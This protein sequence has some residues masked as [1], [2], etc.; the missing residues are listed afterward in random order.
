MILK[1]LK[2]C[3]HKENEREWCVEGKPVNDEYGQWLTFNQINLIVGRNASGKTKTVVVI[4]RIADLLAGDIKL[5]DLIYDTASYE[6]LFQDGTDEINY[7]LDFENGKITQ[8]TLSINGTEKLNRAKETLFYEEIG[9]HLSFKTDDDS[10]ALARRDSKQQPF[11]ES[12]YSWGKNLTHYRFAEQLGQDAFLKDINRV[13]EDTKIN[14]KDGDAV[15]KA[16]VK[17]K[18]L[19]DA[20]FTDA[21]IRDMRK[22][23]YPIRQ[24]D[25]APLKHW[26]IGFALNVQEE[27]LNDVT[28]QAEMSQGMFRALSLLIQI[29]YS[30]FAKTASCILIDDIGEGLDYERSKGLIDLIIEKVKDSSI[31]VI[32]TSNDRF[33]MNKIPLEYWSVIHRIKNKSVFYNYT[34][35][36]Q[37]FDD[38]VFTG[39]NNFD[40]FATDFFIHGF[41]EYVKDVK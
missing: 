4:R 12:L 19:F 41:E 8:E 34:N 1:A 18:H 27:E 16:F 21:V 26:S 6:L 31:Q 10:L 11:F 3:R 22:V 25:I 23:D 36:K 13:K 17:G 2:Y 15:T 5:S 33:V 30:L 7:F 9:K 35:A 20:D 24:I 28:D 29:N 14:L 38:F 37:T 40:F 39:L 32:V